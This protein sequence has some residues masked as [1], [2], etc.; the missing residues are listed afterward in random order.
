MGFVAQIA[1]T[2]EDDLFGPFDA[3]RTCMGKD[4]SIEGHL[5]RCLHCVKYFL[6]TA[7]TCMWERIAVKS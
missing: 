2:Y 7:Y 4:C 3:L 6:Q 5:F 1:E